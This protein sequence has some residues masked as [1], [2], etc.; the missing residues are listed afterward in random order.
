MRTKGKRRYYRSQNIDEPIE[1]VAWLKPSEVDNYINE[2]VDSMG[3]SLTYEKECSGFVDVNY[4][5]YKK[6]KEINAY[7]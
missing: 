1:H 4:R 3:A 7:E 2:V 5:Y 6:E